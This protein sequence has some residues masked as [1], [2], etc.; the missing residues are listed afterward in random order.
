MALRTNVYQNNNV[1]LDSD[2][3]HCDIKTEPI[4]LLLVGLTAGHKAVRPADEVLW[5]MFS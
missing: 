3:L 5:Y 2:H 4:C 1:W